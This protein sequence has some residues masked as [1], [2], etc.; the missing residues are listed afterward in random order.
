MKEFKAYPNNISLP[1]DLNVTRIGLN[2]DKGKNVILCIVEETYV[3][4]HFM[5]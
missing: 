3:M 5:I 1:S 4:K 2:D